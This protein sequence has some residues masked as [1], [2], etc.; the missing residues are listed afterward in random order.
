MSTDNSAKTTV[1][2]PNVVVVP[3]NDQNQPQQSQ[4]AHSSR[5]SPSP[6]SI[7]RLVRAASAERYPVVH[8]NEFAEPPKPTVISPVAINAWRQSGVISGK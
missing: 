3:I 8:P 7:P 4:A 1:T 6:G 2:S 5:V